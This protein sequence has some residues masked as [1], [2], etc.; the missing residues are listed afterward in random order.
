[1]ASVANLPSKSYS[2]MSLRELIDLLKARLEAKESANRAAVLGQPVMVVPA[3][4]KKKRLKCGAVLVQTV[5]VVLEASSSLFLAAPNVPL[6]RKKTKKQEGY[7]CTITSISKSSTNGVPLVVWS[8]AKM[9]T[10]TQSFHPSCSHT[11]QKQEKR[12]SQQR[13]SLLSPWTIVARS[14]L[15]FV[16]QHRREFFLSAWGYQGLQP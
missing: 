16:Q 5:A 3:P 6:R 1:M 12:S 13:R 14:L 10:Q 8:T 2:D 4:K 7:C 11:M 9:H 15:I